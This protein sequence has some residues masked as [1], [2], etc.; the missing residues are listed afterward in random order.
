[1]HIHRDYKW[2]S[3]LEFHCIILKIDLKC[4]YFLYSPPNECIQTP[5]DKTKSENNVIYLGFICLI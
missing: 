5:L 4:A 1:M 2:L 3:G